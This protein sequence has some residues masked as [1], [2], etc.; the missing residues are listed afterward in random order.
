[1]QMHKP[2]CYFQRF[3][4]STNQYSIHSVCAIAKKKSQTVALYKGNNCHVII[5]NLV[6]CTVRASGFKIYTAI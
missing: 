1:M 3:Y 5:Q 6:L 2:Q 4:G